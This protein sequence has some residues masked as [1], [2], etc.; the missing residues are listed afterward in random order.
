MLVR[1]PDCRWDIALRLFHLRERNDIYV[2]RER[3]MIISRKSWL[4]E[5]FLQRYRGRRLPGCRSMTVL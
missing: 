2:S 3:D 5:D 1:N 4:R